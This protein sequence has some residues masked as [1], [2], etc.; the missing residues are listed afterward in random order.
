MLFDM[1]RH[2]TLETVPWHFITTAV[3]M[4]CVTA[5]T[6]VILTDSIVPNARLKDICFTRVV[7]SGC[8]K[9]SNVAPRIFAK[10]SS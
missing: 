10:S 9:G 3:K 4:Y 1:E 2:K 8:T 5:H 6:A 7:S